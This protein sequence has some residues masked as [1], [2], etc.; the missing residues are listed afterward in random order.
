MSTNWCAPIVTVPEGDERIRLCV[1]YSKLNENVK[2]EN[3]SLLST[4]QLLAELDRA[5][6]FTKVNCISGFY[7]IVLRNDLQELMT[8]IDSVT[9]GSLLE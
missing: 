2:W 1:D 8:M 6:V 3:F 7:P 4:D 9:K 5:I